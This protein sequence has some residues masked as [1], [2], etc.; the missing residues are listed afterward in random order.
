MLKGSKQQKAPKRELPFSGLR[1]RKAKDPGTEAETDMFQAD[2][3]LLVLVPCR[4]EDMKAGTSLVLRSYR[5]SCSTSS[6]SLYSLSAHT[7]T[8]RHANREW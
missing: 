1:L 6:T 4:R 5:G 2:K 8:L 3:L 7:K